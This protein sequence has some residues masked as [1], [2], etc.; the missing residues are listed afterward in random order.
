MNEIAEKF[1][2]GT[3]STTERQAV[4]R[5]CLYNPELETAIV[6][7][8][9]IYG[10]LL[11]DAPLSSDDAGLWDRIDSALSFELAT[12][13]DK[14]VETFSEGGWEPHGRGIDVK[15]LWSDKAI[16]IRCAPGGVEEEHAQPEDEDEHIIVVAGDLNLGGR[17]FSTGDYICIPAASKHQQMYSKGGC[18]LFTQYKLAGDGL[19]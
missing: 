12:L 6:R 16:L 17:S 1:V 15:S 13:G 10:T 7:L 19:R 3:L 11:E 9:K 14:C 18:I 8:E 4:L 5:E 2:M